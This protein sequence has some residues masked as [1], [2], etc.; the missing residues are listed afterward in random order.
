[1]K[2]TKI[3]TVLVRS[4]NMV[5]KILPSVQ[6]TCSKHFMQTKPKKIYFDL[7]LVFLTKI[8]IFDQNFDF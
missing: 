8:Y 7:K 1:M 2:A 6:F 3:I 5:P 4:E